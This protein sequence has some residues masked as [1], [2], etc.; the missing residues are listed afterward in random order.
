MGPMNSIVNL[1]HILCKYFQGKILNTHF[2]LV[3]CYFIN[4]L[5]INL[6]LFVMTEFH[7]IS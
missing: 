1:V 4:V 5:R 7:G 6:F 2:V 3:Y